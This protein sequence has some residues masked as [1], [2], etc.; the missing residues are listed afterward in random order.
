M[1]EPMPDVG[2]WTGRTAKARNDLAHEG[3]TPNHII[4]EL[5]AVVEPDANCVA[6]PAQVLKLPERVSDC[7]YVHSQTEVALAYAEQRLQTLRQRHEHARRPR[8]EVSKT[9]RI[10][11][12]FRPHRVTRPLHPP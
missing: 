9:E 5:V 12:R 10:G 4:E 3:D 1:S 8:T 7:D 2:R 6:G 11:T